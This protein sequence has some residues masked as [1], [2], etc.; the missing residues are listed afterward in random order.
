[1]FSQIW[2]IFS[3]P[4]VVKT[5]SVYLEQKKFVKVPGGG[6]LI[7]KHLDDLHTGMWRW[8]WDVI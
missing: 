6:F 1:M 4:E 2:D 3:F 8:N 7:L 5:L